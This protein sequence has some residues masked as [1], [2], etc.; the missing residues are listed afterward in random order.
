MMWKPGT[1]QPNIQDFVGH[2]HDDRTKRRSNSNSKRRRD[3]EEKRRQD[4]NENA[5]LFKPTTGVVTQLSQVT[6]KMRFMQRNKSSTISQTQLS[7]PAQHEQ[8]Q[9]YPK[10]SAPF[11]T[12]YSSSHKQKVRQFGN[13]DDDTHNK[14]PK[15]S[16]DVDEENDQMDR[17]GSSDV[18]ELV[19]MQGDNETKQRSNTNHKSSP[20]GHDSWNDA[21]VPSRAPQHA[22]D[23]ASNEEG[24]NQNSASSSSFAITKTTPPQ[25]G[26]NDISSSTSTTNNNTIPL[27]RQYQ[28]MIASSSDMYGVSGMI[29]GRRSFGG[30]DKYV[31]ENYYYSSLY[32][33]E[34]LPSAFDDMNKRETKKKKKRRNTATVSNDNDG[35]FHHNDDDGDCDN[36]EY[37][38]KI[39]IEKQ[40]RYKSL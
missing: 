19:P 35:N 14:I 28:P 38:D 4:K 9:Q 25:S 20:C 10:P 26:S 23:S 12:T 29:L 30:F 5:L 6:R 34:I 8:Q 11:N 39:S 7:S 27:Q 31:A 21:V 15:D 32:V 37:N 22:F 24:R 13:D 18:D 1:V 16:M 33:K 40:K 2:A 36:N 17:N 3:D